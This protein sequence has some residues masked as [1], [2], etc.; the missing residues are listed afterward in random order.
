MNPATFPKIQLKLEKRKNVGQLT[1]SS[2]E[3]EKNW[4]WNCSENLEVYPVHS[5]V[6]FCLFLFSINST[7]YVQFDPVRILCCTIICASSLGATLIFSILHESVTYF[8]QHD[9]RE[10]LSVYCRK[11]MRLFFLNLYEL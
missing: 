5:C 6:P 2:E 7:C 10:K 4:Q 9:L 1:S 11:R 8:V 3:P